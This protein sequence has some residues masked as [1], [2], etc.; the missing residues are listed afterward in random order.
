MHASYFH[1]TPVAKGPPT[2]E[3]RSCRESKK[4][5]TKGTPIVFLA[6]FRLFLPFFGLSVPDRLWPSVFAL[7]R[8]IRLLPF[9]KNLSRLSFRNSLKRLKITLEF[10]NDLKR[11]FLNLVLRVFFEHPKLLRFMALFPF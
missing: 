11:L 7:F 5:S 4:R 1:K 6:L 9:P 10:K 2:K 3:H 8:T